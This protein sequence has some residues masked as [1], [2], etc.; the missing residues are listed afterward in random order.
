MPVYHSL[1][2][3]GWVNNPEALYRDIV[4]FNPIRRDLAVQAGGRAGAARTSALG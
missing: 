4:H 1:K 3:G 2:Y